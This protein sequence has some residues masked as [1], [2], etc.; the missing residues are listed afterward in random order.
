MRDSALSSVLAEPTWTA[1]PHV[2]HQTAQRL[3]L[4]LPTGHHHTPRPTQRALAIASKLTI[5]FGLLGGVE[6]AVPP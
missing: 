6:Y 4:R 3:A 1:M 2:H 5:R